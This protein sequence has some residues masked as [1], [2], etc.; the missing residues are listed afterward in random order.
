MRGETGTDAG[1]AQEVE[2]GEGRWHDFTPQAEREVRIGTA[3]D[4]NKM[5]FPRT[6]GAFGGIA[7][8][9]VGGRGSKFDAFVGHEFLE[10]LGGEGGA[11]EAQA[12]G[13]C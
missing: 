12:Q 5:I 2:G 13:H 10:G 7:A 3:E 11:E 8:V 6:G 9:A 1:A 4:G